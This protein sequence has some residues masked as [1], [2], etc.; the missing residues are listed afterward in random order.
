MRKWVKT[1]KPEFAKMVVEGSKCSTIRPWPKDN[2]LPN[3]GDTLDAR[4]WK[5]KA[6]HSP[7]LIL[8]SYLIESV[9]PVIFVDDSIFVQ[10]TKNSIHFSNKINPKLADEWAK[11]DGF[12]SAE[13]MF[14]WF[15]DNY[16]MPFVGVRIKWADLK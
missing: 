12:K 13:E 7:Q 2:K 8:A 6:Y 1:F 14:G 5:G 3:A 10:H 9:T 11:M 4:M 16:K 15:K